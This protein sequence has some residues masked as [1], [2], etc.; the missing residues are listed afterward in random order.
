MDDSARQIKFP[1]NEWGGS[2]H[3]NYCKMGKNWQKYSGIQVWELP[4][5]APSWCLTE[6]QSRHWNSVRILWII[7]DTSGGTSYQSSA[8]RW[9]SCPP[10]SSW[11]AHRPSPPQELLSRPCTCKLDCDNAPKHFWEPSVINSPHLQE[12]MVSRIFSVVLIFLRP[13]MDEFTI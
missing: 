8:R 9:R 4:L 1:T 13:L 11:H 2:L 6:V 5:V 10:S 7:G 12:F 3:S